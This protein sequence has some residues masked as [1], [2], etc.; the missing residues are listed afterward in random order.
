[1]FD[2]SKSIFFREEQAELEAR[3]QEEALRPMLVQSNAF[4]LDLNKPIMRT[5][6]VSIKYYDGQF[7]NDTIQPARRIDYE[8]Q[9]TIVPHESISQRYWVSFEKKN[10]Y[11]NRHE[12]DLVAEELAVRLMEALNPIR[13]LV[14]PSNTIQN[15]I[16]NHEEILRNWEKVKNNIRDKFEGELTEKL[17]EKVEKT[18]QN[19]VQILLRLEKDMFWSAYFA[20]IYGV[21]PE[22]LSRE[23][24]Q[25]FP[26]KPKGLYPFH[27]IQKVRKYKTDY[28]TYKIDFEGQAKNKDT[29]KYNIDLD[30]NNRILKYM[31]IDYYQADKK[32]IR[33][34]AYQT[35]T[36]GMVSPSLPIEIQEQHTK[37]KVG[38]WDFLFG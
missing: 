14:D 10:L 37:D 21:Y 34:S 28:E 19:Q 11:I 38:F 35:G 2:R 30:V 16:E 6:G 13:V 25:L 18:I 22:M 5:Y 23:E 4:Y 8:M 33:F 27:G 3:K 12:A 7:V 24:R 32:E 26:L 17:L 29:L 9:V 1:M 36:D 15:G 20:P 31:V